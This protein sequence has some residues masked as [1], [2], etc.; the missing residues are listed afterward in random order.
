MIIVVLIDYMITR[1]HC[2]FKDVKTTKIELGL[3]WPNFGLFVVN[4][5]FTDELL[6]LNNL[7]FRKNR[8]MNLRFFLSF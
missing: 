8:S 6:D 2:I 1:K 5:L 3:R 7:L 4:D